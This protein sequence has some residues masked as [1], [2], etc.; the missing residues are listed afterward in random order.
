M[1]RTKISGGIE[2][3]RTHGL[4]LT[5]TV[6]CTCAAVSAFPRRAH[7]AKFTFFI[8][9]TLRPSAP[10]KRTSTSRIALLSILWLQSAITT[11][12]NDAFVTGRVWRVALFRGVPITALIDIIFL[13]DS[14]AACRR[15]T[16]LRTKI[17]H[18]LPGNG[19]PVDAI[20]GSKITEFRS[21]YNAITAHG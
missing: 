10:H 20:E 19:F 17:I 14:I 13:Y 12:H 9:R 7:G 11:A 3:K 4:P 1:L 5:V 16:L 21:L 18:S 8:R 15:F 2:I 6:L